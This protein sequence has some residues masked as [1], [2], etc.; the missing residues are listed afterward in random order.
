MG[1]LVC[2]AFLQNAKLGDQKARDCVDKFFTYAT[3][4]NG[5]EMAGI[6]VPEFLGVNDIN[7]F[8][9]DR[10]ADYL[11]SVPCTRRRSA[12]TGSRK[13]ISV[14][15]DLLHGRHESRRLRRGRPVCR[16]RSQAT[17]ATAW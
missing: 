4:H 6:N 11:D 16:A 10:M 9:R 2:R 17:A 3:P 15:N 1:G 14:R 8:N 13:K 7:N 5:I 12:S